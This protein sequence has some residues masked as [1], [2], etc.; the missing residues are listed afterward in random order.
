[1][2]WGRLTD[3]FLNPLKSS[4]LSDEEGISPDDQRGERLNP[5]K[6]SQLS[7]WIKV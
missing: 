3:M 6:S 7:D 1:M 5:L 4:Q 2:I